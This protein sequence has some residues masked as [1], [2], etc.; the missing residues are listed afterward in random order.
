MSRKARCVI[1]ALVVL[2]AIGCDATRLTFATPPPVVARASPPPDDFAVRF[3]RIVLK[4]GL[5]A[6]V[7]EDH[8]APV[9]SLCITYRVGSRYD[10]VARPGTAHLLEYMMFQGSR[11][12]RRGEHF[13]LLSQYGGNVNG[14]TAAEASMFC[15]SLLST[16]LDLGLFLEA[17]RMAS[18]EITQDNLRNQLDA[19]V[20]ERARTIDNQV[21]GR[22]TEAVL[23]TAFD[24][25]TY[26]HS[27]LGSPDALRRTTVEELKAFF[28]RHYCPNN[29][30]LTLVGNV[31]PADALRR[32]DRY[33]ANIPA[34]APAAVPPT[35]ERP[36]SAERRLVI[37][38]HFARA[39]RIDI[40]YKVV[41]RT[42]PDSKALYVLGQV[43]AVGQSSR[44]YRRLVAGGLATSVGGGFQDR[45]GPT[46]LVTVA[47]VAPG[48]A[49][50]QVER[51]THEETDLLIASP[52][53]QSEID[54]VRTR[55]RAERSEWVRN[56][57]QVATRLGYNA[58][59]YDDPAVVN[60]MDQEL[61]QVSSAELQRV[62]R[63]YL[64]QANR[65]VVVTTPKR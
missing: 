37:E 40:A 61:A 24:D 56:T 43:L 63:I 60:T 20:E 49:A 16:Q 22:T 17:D 31:R 48:T 52:V 26:K 42:R 14:S 65:S 28:R 29:A 36:Q 55:W 39:T 45:G 2:V 51:A 27:T 21:Y 12:V 19:I 13:L 35:A 10:D 50:E 59:I 46:L 1:A 62:A 30:V 33:F 3:H 9:Y 34:G 53:A 23:D 25:P 32:I 58:A 41:G 57:L 54:A 44:L 4:N 5:R 64:R 18:L 47:V 6:I 38:D 11:N 8:S 15:Q 7:A